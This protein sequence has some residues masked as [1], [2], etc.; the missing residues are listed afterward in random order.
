MIN[1]VFVTGCR[2]L[3][4]SASRP[5]QR[6]GSYVSQT[7]LGEIECPVSRYDIFFFRWGKLSIIQTTYFPAIRKYFLFNVTIK[8]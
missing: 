8:E 1:P 2:V 3:D 5:A 6:I 4:V 7:D